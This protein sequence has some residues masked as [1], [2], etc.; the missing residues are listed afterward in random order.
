MFFDERGEFIPAV[1]VTAMFADYMLRKH[2]PNKIIVDLRLV[3]PSLKTIEKNGGQAIIT[4]GGHAFMKDRLR[5][6]NALFGGETVG[7]YYFRDNFY[8][9]NGVIPFLMMLEIKSRDKRPLSQIAAP[10]MEGHHM[11]GERNFRVKDP[12]GIIAKVQEQLG[13]QGAEDF[14]DG[15]TLATET[16][17]IN[18]RPSNTEPLLRLNIE[19]RQ[20]EA[21]SE[22]LQQIVKIIEAE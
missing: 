18:I 14:M 8:S 5:R 11:S 20:Q 15:Y 4:K 21:I 7:H 13:S 12:K 3:W 22:V 10:F 19:A 17:R 9:D 6:E 16:W 2:G 1:Y